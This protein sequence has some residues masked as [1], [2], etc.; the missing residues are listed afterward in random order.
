MNVSTRTLHLP[1]GQAVTSPVRERPVRERG[2]SAL[3]E[4][5]TWGPPDPATRVLEPCGA[6]AVLAVIRIAHAPWPAPNPAMRI[7]MA[8]PVAVTAP[9]DTGAVEPFHP[10]DMPD[11]VAA[12]RAAVASP[13]PAD[14]PWPAPTAQ[15]AA[16][17]VLATP[18][19]SH[20][21]ML[22]ASDADRTGMSRRV[23]IGFVAVAGTA[24]AAVAAAV[25]F[26]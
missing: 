23:A 20:P 2:A 11:V 14:Q 3:D 17:V 4:R 18:P 7:D 1:G 21:D 5:S 6:P 13:A 10:I 12:R 25:A 9:V 26:L 19:A 16:A 22:R 15:E 24:C 8:P